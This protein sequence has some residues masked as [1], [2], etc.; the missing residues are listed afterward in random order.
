[1][2]AEYIKTWELR[3][4]SKAVQL[5]IFI[6]GHATK[7]PGDK[8]GG[9]AVQLT[10]TWGKLAN[11]V[12]MSK[13]SCRRVVSMLAKNGDVAHRSGTDK[14]IITLLKYNKISRA[15]QKCGTPSRHTKPIARAHELIDFLSGMKEYSERNGVIEISLPVHKGGTR[16][17]E[18]R[19]RDDRGTDVVLGVNVERYKTERLYA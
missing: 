9:D 16:V 5:L 17:P 2:I 8:F 3:K 15:M 11:D 6:V 19:F 18:V 7:T 12:G 1:M 14:T 13:S 4:N 10:T